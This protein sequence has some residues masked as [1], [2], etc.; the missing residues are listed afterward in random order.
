MTMPSTA[1]S[2]APARKLMRL[3]A[4]LTKALAGATTL[5]AILVVRVASINPAGPMSTA[6]ATS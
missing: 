4:R 1:V 6:A 5:A 3:G 2:S